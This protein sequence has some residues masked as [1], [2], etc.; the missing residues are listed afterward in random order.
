MLALF[1]KSGTE[2]VAH[3][4]Y[5]RDFM[6]IRQS[7]IYNGSL[8]AYKKHPQ[9]DDGGFYESK[10]SLWNYIGIMFGQ[11]Q[12]IFNDVSGGMVYVRL[13]C[14]T[15]STCR[16]TR[17]Y[18]DQEDAMRQILV[19]DQET[20][21]GSVESSFFD[22]SAIRPDLVEVQGAFYVR[23]DASTRSIAGLRIGAN[24][25]VKV[26]IARVDMPHPTRQG[27]T[28][29]YSLDLMTLRSRGLHYFPTRCATGYVC[30]VNGTT[31]CD[32][33]FK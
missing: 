18:C 13:G 5:G 25:V 15:N 29:S 33:C 14:P 12:G 11:V 31:G 8:F 17:L 1:Q 24:V 19:S 23:C 2:V 16:V 4:E 22:Y 32:L 10:G 3:A 6:A 20:L 7:S 27:N 21:N 9:E 28:R 26:T 30:D